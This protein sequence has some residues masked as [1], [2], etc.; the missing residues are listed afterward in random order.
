MRRLLAAGALTGLAV[1]PAGCTAG[2]GDRR[3]AA[4]DAK[5]IAAVVEPAGLPSGG[6]APAVVRHA[7]VRVADSKLGRILVDG[8]GRTLYAFGKDV[9]GLPA[10]YD[11][12]AATWHPYLTHGA[13]EAASGVDRDLLGIA[14]RADGTTQVA[15]GGRPLYRYTGDARAGQVTGHGLTR[16]GGA[17]H[18]LTPRGTS[19]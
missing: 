1:A 9:D 3:A 10:C 4:P 18:A 17:W 8:E 6:D 7:P 19:P 2:P 15:Y 12:C 11:E 5:T 16:H 13:P 14:D